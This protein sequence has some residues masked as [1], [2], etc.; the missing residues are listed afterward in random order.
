MLSFIILSVVMLSVIM[1]S[2]VML[3]VVMLSVIILSVVMLSVIILSVV[4]HSVVA[5]SKKNLFHVF[6]RIIMVVVINEN[7]SR[8]TNFVLTTLKRASLVYTIFVLARMEAGT[9]KFRIIR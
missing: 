9:H 2:V 4:M 8:F 5:P 1:L 3:S 7:Y 6:L